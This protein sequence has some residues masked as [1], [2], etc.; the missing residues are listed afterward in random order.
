VSFFVPA[1]NVFEKIPHDVRE[2]VNQGAKGPVFVR[3]GP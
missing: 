2:F 3:F 1:A